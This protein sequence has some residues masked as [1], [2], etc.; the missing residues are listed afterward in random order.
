MCRNT[1]P[2]AILAPTR[3]SRRKQNFRC[4]PAQQTH[5]DVSSLKGLG[6]QNGVTAG[7]VVSLPQKFL[8]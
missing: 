4:L 6:K 8:E 2:A 3:A 1:I 5:A 7:I